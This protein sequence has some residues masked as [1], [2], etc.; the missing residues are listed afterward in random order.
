MITAFS[1]IS[2]SAWDG[3][4]LVAL[5]GV[6]VAL[7]LKID[8]FVKPY[9]ENTQER[10]Q[11]IIRSTITLAVN[12]ATALTLGA[13]IGIPALTA[14]S[15]S[16][17]ALGIF[18]YCRSER[19]RLENHL[20]AFHREVSDCNKHSQSEQRLDDLEYFQGLIIEKIDFHKARIDNVVNLFK[21]IENESETY[22][23]ALKLV[24]TTVD[25]I[26]K[27]MITTEAHEAL[28]MNVSSLTNV[29]NEMTRQ[30]MLLHQLLSGTAT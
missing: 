6:P 3:P 15:V 23:E 26:E 12:A 9:F 1:Q 2:S 11:K 10:T 5:A 8:D 30:Q 29:I 22:Q 13:L 27:N 28:K 24:R 18:T 25:N 19:F 17:L 7:S 16:F 20:N 14:I 4:L 21:E